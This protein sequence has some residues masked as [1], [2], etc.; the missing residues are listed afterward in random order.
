MTAD[1]RPDAAP[2]RWRRPPVPREGALLVAVGLAVALAWAAL[3]SGA[4]EARFEPLVRAGSGQSPPTHSM[5]DM[6]WM[7]GMQMNHPTSAA[8]PIGHARPDA[9][10]FM[11]MWAFMIC[12]MMLPLALPA[13]RHVAANS[14]RWRRRRAMVAFIA[15]YVSCWVLAGLSA[16]GVWLILRSSSSGSAAH[17]AGV[18]LLACAVWQIIPAKQAALRDCHRSSPLPAQGRAATV[19]VARFAVRHGFACVRSC[20]PLMLALVFVPAYPAMAMV[21]AAAVLGFERRA[22]RPRR[23]ARRVAWVLVLC[24]VLVA[25]IG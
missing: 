1:L 5:P 17:I 24:G 22:Q 20:G 4:L 18:G 21:S 13:L 6:L 23:A 7:P 8:P 11:A 14:L 16:M 25:V 12:A 15:A 3:L 2:I 9:G 19:G 10:G